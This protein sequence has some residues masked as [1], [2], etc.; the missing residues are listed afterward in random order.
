MEW[1][2]EWL[3]QLIRNLLVNEGNPVIRIIANIIGSF[4]IWACYLLFSG[5]THKLK[6]KYPA[7]SGG[8]ETKIVEKILVWSTII[9]IALLLLTGIIVV[10][11][12]LIQEIWSPGDKASASQ[13]GL[14]QAVEMNLN[15]FKYVAQFVCF[16]LVLMVALASVQAVFIVFNSFRVKSVTVESIMISCLSCGRETPSDEAYCHYCGA[17]LS[18]KR[19]S[20]KVNKSK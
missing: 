17:N 20:L 10:F 6:S 9:L 3:T 18:E 5:L 2:T 11:K 12:A 7:A 1:F 8:L 19:K 16:S 13:I 4:L 14:K 15:H